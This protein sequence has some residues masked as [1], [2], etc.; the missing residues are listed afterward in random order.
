[1]SLRDTLIKPRLERMRRA[2]RGGSIALLNQSDGYEC[3][4]A[5]AVL[6]KEA[7]GDLGILKNIQ[8][9][10]D[11]WGEADC[12][13]CIIPHRHMHEAIHKIGEAGKSVSLLESDSAMHGSVASYVNVWWVAGNDVRTQ[14]IQKVKTVDRNEFPSVWD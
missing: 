5:D 10:P 7:I 12:E 4:L 11:N 6:V 3:Y 13:V 14:A 8:V 1:M 2:A 9:D